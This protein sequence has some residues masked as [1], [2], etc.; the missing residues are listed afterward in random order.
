MPSNRANGNTRDA[1]GRLVTCEQTG[2]RVSRTEHNGTVVTL[3]NMHSNKT[4]N[5]PNDVAVKS[6][7]TIWFSDPNYGG[8][9]TQ[10]GRYV[11]RFHPDSVPQKRDCPL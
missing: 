11:Y 8:S 10:P 1:E 3:V 7:G 2:R 4:F 9:D 5:A 6:D